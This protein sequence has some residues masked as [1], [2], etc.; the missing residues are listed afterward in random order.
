MTVLHYALVWYFI[1][2]FVIVV[3]T[4]AFFT[5][6]TAISLG[7]SVVS[8]LIPVSYERNVEE[9][10]SSE[11]LHLVRLLVLYGMLSE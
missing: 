7:L 2:N 10:V 9:H 8:N 4:F 11:Y 3:N 5:F 6:V 1:P